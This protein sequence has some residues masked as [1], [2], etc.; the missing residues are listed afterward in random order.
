VPPAGA[1]DC[2]F[3]VFGP[4]DRFP[5]ADD[6]GYTPPEASVGSYKTVMAALG[7]D[8]CV[9]VQPSVYGTDNTATL[10]AARALG[11]PKFCK[12]VA[13]IDERIDDATLGMLN[14][15]GVVGVRFN[16]VAGGGP[17]LARIAEVTK[18]IADFGWHL[19]IYAP[20]GTLAGA[21]AALQSLPVDVVI[22]HFGAIDPKQGIDGADCQAL[23]GL[24]RDGR[25]WIKMSGGYISS[26]QDSP[27]HDMAA[28]ARRLVEVRPDRLLWGTNWPHPVCY[29]TM[30]DDGDLLDALSAWVCDAHLLHRILVANPQSLYFDRPNADVIL[31]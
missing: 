29:G 16:L 23:L 9:I 21:A 6:R 3:H 5:L 8:R 30:P 17:A 24:L 14:D 28:V 15:A 11:G 20:G 19:Q 18:R 22:D 10:Q 7:L 27:W 31:P 2:H 26:H 4:Y 25:T 13:V 1:C 12:I